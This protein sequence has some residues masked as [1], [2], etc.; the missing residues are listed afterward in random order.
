MTELPNS[1]NPQVLAVIKAMAQSELSCDNI[2]GLSCLYCNGEEKPSLLEIQDV[3][4]EPDCPVTTAR[5]LLATWGMPLNIYLLTGQQRIGPRGKWS[6]FAQHDIG[7]SP[8]ETHCYSIV[9]AGQ[10]VTYRN[11][12]IEFVR[13]FPI[14]TIE[15]QPET[16]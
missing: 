13:A 10:S 11:V 12:T 4:H 1:I 2:T 3:T 5:K 14:E 16:R 8:E 6:D 9:S 7:T 15:V